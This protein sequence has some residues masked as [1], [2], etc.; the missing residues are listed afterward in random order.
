MKQ[1]VETHFFFIHITQTQKELKVFVN[2]KVD[3]KE[4]LPNG[5]ILG[6]TALINEVK[7]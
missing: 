2:R 5:Y 3:G 1:I 4:E 7:K 6:V